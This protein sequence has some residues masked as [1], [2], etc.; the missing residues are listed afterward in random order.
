MRGRSLVGPFVLILL[1][2]A[3]LIN[4]VRPDLNL[5]TF[6]ANYWPFLLIG[7]GTLRLLEILAYAAAAK[8]LPRQGLSGGEIFLAVVIVIIGSGMFEVRRHLGVRFPFR[9]PT[10]EVFG[11]SFD[12][13]IS[14]Q[15]AIG[16][17]SRILFDNV[18][19]NV[20]VTGADAAEI[21]IS[22]RKTVRAYNKADADKVNEQ[23]P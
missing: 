15:K 16:E 9:R 4:N 12:Y 19:G 8:P 5:F 7:M 2:A 13:P 17:K 11:E 3:F 6:L 14:Q 22:G 20:R 1:G 21:R 18:R 23:S 10:L